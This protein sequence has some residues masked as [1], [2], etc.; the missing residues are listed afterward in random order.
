MH[1]DNHRG[2]RG[3]KDTNR[4]SDRHLA[5]TS[6][7]W[8]R[9][10]TGREV[11]A[12]ASAPLPQPTTPSKMHKE[13]PTR[14]AMQVTGWEQANV[15]RSRPSGSSSTKRP[16][17]VV[18]GG[19]RGG[20]DK[21]KSPKTLF[22]GGEARENGSGTMKIKKKRR[23]KQ[24]KARG[25]EELPAKVRRLN[26]DDTPMG[27]ADAKHGRKEASLD[28]RQ[29]Q[30]HRRRI[31]KKGATRADKPKK[32]TVVKG[33]ADADTNA[34]AVKDDK[35]EDRAEELPAGGVEVAADGNG[36]TWGEE[37]QVACGK[38]ETEDEDD[39]EAEFEWDGGE[40]SMKVAEKENLESSG[41]NK[42]GQGGIIMMNGKEEARGRPNTD[43]EEEDEESQVLE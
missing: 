26:E 24:D 2:G 9:E 6:N 23:R 16:L 33:K 32:A 31:T 37:N 36:R 15:Y 12:K 38:G 13:E 35:P 17:A 39:E 20:D 3:D 27:S 11:R 19:G 7:G 40:K 42:Q 18:A 41:C 34:K 1:A 22:K 8:E 21:Q 25:A 14:A 29:D 28:K 5:K 30:Q 43:D 10:E 4:L